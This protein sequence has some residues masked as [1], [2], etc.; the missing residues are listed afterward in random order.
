MNDGVCL[1]NMA[2][3]GIVNEAALA[4]ALQEG[5]IACAGT[6]VL[7]EEPGGIGTSPLLPDVSK[8]QK[9]VPNL[10]ISP[11]VSWFSVKTVEMLHKLLLEG[12]VGFVEGKTVKNNVVVLDGKIYK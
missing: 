11:H 6:D 12:V 8:G 4:T 7:E 2:R 1:I 5:W 9:P 10:V 3:G